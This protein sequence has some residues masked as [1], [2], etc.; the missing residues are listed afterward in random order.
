MKCEHVCE[1]LDLSYS[2]I[3][4]NMFTHFMLLIKNGAFYFINIC[5]IN[6][7]AYQKNRIERLFFIAIQCQEGIW[8]TLYSLASLILP[9]LIL[10]P[11]HTYLSYFLISQK[12]KLAHFLTNSYINSPN[13]YYLS[14]P[15]IT[16][17]K[18]YCYIIFLFIFIPLLVLLILTFF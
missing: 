15:F 4:T 9:H 5:C 17:L 16:A 3:F 10:L 1:N 2:F 13:C 12:G 6:S 14:Q 7:N 8:F 11:I 18:H